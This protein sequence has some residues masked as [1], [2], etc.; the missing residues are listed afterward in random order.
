QDLLTA[1]SRWLADKT[2][3]EYRIE[4]EGIVV[5]PNFID[6]QRFRPADGTA[7]RRELGAEGRFL[8]THVS[9]FRPVKRVKDVVSGFAALRQRQDA[10]LAL[11]GSG[12]DLDDA[13]RLADVLGVREHVRALGKLDDLETVLQASDV[14]FL[15]SVAESFG[16]AALEAQACGC[17]VIGYRAG[18]LPEVVIDHETGILCPEGEDVCLGSLAADL[19]GD[20]ERFRA[21][22]QA[23]RR[24]AERFAMTPIVASYEKALCCLV[25]ANRVCDAATMADC[26]HTQ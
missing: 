17:P 7:K 1:P 4:G 22:R 15:P 3:T 2:E 26:A 21:M 12:P 19:L 16:L 6:L 8:V 23:S 10:V 13:L 5:I 14:F 9:N 18:G 11:V 20:P 24:N 25:H